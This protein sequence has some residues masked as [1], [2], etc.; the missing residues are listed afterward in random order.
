MLL[1]G[2]GRVGNI[3]QHSSLD[4]L[5]GHCVGTPFEIVN[6]HM[7]AKILLTSTSTLRKGWR[8]FPHFFIGEGCNLKSARFNVIK[9]I[10]YLEEEAEARR[11]NGTIQAQGQKKGMVCSLHAGRK[12]LQKGRVPNKV[13]GSGMARKRTTPKKTS[14][15]ID[16][17]GDP[18][19]ICK[20]IK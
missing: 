3:V 6:I 17:G 1:F 16:T 20:G 19:D 5:P 15:R 14:R 18:F 9:V 2:P 4:R 12:D 8:R 11:S 10:N 7:L 13:R